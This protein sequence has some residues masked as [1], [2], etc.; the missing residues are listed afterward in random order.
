MFTT[1]DLKKIRT[2]VR[3]EV[4]LGNESLNRDLQG[5]IKLSRIE[6][7]NEIRMLKNQLKNI[8]KKNRSLLIS[9]LQ[10]SASA[11]K[12]RPYRSLNPCL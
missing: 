1:S 3:E 12:A 2:I 9:C 11:C 8:W 10:V 5:E 6:I 7:Q 4:E